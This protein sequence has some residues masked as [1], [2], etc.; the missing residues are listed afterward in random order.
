MAKMG[1]ELRRFTI[2]WHN[3]P[4][5]KYGC[6]FKSQAE[7]RWADYLEI[8]KKLDAIVKW[9]YEPETFECGSKYRKERIYTPDFRITEKMGSHIYQVYHEVKVALQQKDI[10]RFK[11]LKSSHSEITIVL[12]LPYS[13]A[14]KTASSRRQLELISN[15]RKYI[16]RIVY[17]NSL[18]KQFGIK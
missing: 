6:H 5:E 15:A 8:L 2:D 10:S 9:E 18:F 14:G 13:P 17:A 7:R 11:W 16:E 3:K 4:E 1:F 12:V